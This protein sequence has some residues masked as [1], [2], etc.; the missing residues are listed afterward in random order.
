MHKNQ[1]NLK[2]FPPLFDCYRLLQ[3][4]RVNANTFSSCLR[5]LLPQC[6][7]RPIRWKA[8]KTEEVRKIRYWSIKKPPPICKA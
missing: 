3:S 8:V 7:E 2:N 1:K 5:D 6:P 4:G